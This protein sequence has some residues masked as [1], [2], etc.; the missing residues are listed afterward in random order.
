MLAAMS[1][2]RQRNLARAAGLAAIAFSGGALSTG[3]SHALTRDESPYRDLDQLGRS[4]VL[5]ENEYVDPVDHARLVQ[6]AIKGMIKELDPHSAYMPK[7]DYAIFRSDTE[8]RFGGIGIEVDLRDDA[9]T[10]IAPIEGTPAHRAGIRSGDRIV[11]VDASPLRA[12]SLEGLVRRLR[13]APG[14]HVK[15]SLRRPGV[16]A[17]LTFDLVREEIHV[18]SIAAKRLLFGVYYVRIKQFQEGTRDEMLSAVAKL[19]EAGPPSGIVLDLRA[20]PGGL[21]DEATEAADEMLDAGTIYTTRHR[22]KVV[23]ELRAHAGGAL[24]GPPMA[25]LVDEYTASAAE[26][27]AGAL[28]DNHRATVVGAP[29]FGKG[30]VQTILELPGGAGLKLTTMRYYTPSGRSIQAQ[31]IQPNVMIGLTA[32]APDVV[33]ERDLPGH[34]PAE[35][36]RSSTPQVLVPAAD[37]GVAPMRVTDVPTDPANGPDYALSIAYQIVRKALGTPR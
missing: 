7:E 5:A 16:D 28:Q 30:S 9:I 26:L 13:G 25:V 35:G 2:I 21:V 8:G 18:T 37:A 3:L 19:R 22:G 34:L 36:A 14:T 1:P 15:L 10:V 32:N 17:P 12:D 23:E 27:V 33:R 20:N 31:G 29:T 24:A 11:A 4:L 6:G